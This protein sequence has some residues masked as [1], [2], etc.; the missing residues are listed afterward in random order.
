MAEALDSV[1][2]LI[3]NLDHQDQEADFEDFDDSPE[4]NSE[5][6][7][8]RQIKTKMPYQNLDCIN[9]ESEDEDAEDKTFNEPSQLILSDS[10]IDQEISKSSLEAFSLTEE[11]RNLKHK[12]NLALWEFVMQN[13]E[14]SVRTVLDIEKYGAF[15]ADP[16]AKGLND[17]TAL[18]TSSAYGYKQVCK[19][20]IQ[21]SG[22]V[23]ARTSIQRTPL[24]LATL[25]NHFRV[26]KLLVKSGA[27]INLKDNEK[28]TALHY[29]ST[30]GYQEI[31]EWLLSK[32]PVFDLNNLG[33]SPFCLSLNYE[34]YSIFIE[35]SKSRG[36][37]LPESGYTRNVVSRTLRHNSREDYVNRLTT[38]CSQKVN[39]KDLKAFTD[40]PKFEFNT[41]KLKKDNEKFILP[42]SKVGPF[43]FK[44]IAQL[45]LVFFG[46]FYFF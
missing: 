26:V 6:D 43:D 27:D 12:M 37:R 36:L 31:V 10:Q 1:K 46:D 14:K 11:Y 17:W 42:P 2:A 28:N 3:K 45:G 30:Q 5:S 33:R 23:N 40:R 16:N 44:G 21:S 19:I 20:L 15:T 38:K 32:E 22:D 41:K 29:A 7:S 39:V 35:Y 9:E 24:H 25:H 4:K 13:D 34:T 18:H 8:K